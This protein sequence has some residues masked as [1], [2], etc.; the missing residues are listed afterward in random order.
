MVNFKILLSHRVALF[1]FLRANRLIVA[2]VQSLQ[3]VMGIFKTN[4]M[5]DQA[6]PAWYKRR[7]IS[8]LVKE[9][10]IDVFVETGTYLGQTIS[11]IYTRFPNVRVKSIEVD[12][13]LF[14][15]VSSRFR[16]ELSGGRLELYLG[17]SSVVLPSVLQDEQDRLL[18]FLDGHFS[19]GIT[20]DYSDCPLIIELQTIINSRANQYT[21]IIIDDVHLFDKLLDYPSWQF[22]NEFCETHGFRWFRRGSLLVLSQTL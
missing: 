13:E 9:H 4:S 1:Q 20:K 14:R 6:S 18:V 17:D 16:N 22:I 19:S 11:L 21:V 3:Y 15:H 2:V 8:K 7:I 5:R 10:S 12:P